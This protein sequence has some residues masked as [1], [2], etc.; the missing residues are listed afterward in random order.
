M[1]QPLRY[2]VPPFSKIS[3]AIYQTT[4]RHSP[5]THL[6]ENLTYF[7]GL[8]A[9]ALSVQQRATFLAAAV[10]FQEK[11]RMCLLHIIVARSEAHTASYPMGARGSF[12]RGK[13]AGS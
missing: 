3:L 13:E 1:S 6:R 11:E 9:S 8:T 4:R 10:R 12:L 5:T 2:R 7:T